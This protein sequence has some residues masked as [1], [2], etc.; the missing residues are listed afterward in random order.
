MLEV[1]PSE[2]CWLLCVEEHEGSSSDGRN[3]IL[4]QLDSMS[5]FN[6]RKMGKCVIMRLFEKDLEWL[7]YEKVT[8]L[9]L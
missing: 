9:F 8:Y 5:I 3:T 7:S 2:A 6:A 4:I 1:V